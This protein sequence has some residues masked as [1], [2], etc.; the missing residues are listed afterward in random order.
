MEKVERANSTTD[1]RS[2]CE[3]A[4]LEKVSRIFYFL[5]CTPNG[6]TKWRWWPRLL[7]LRLGIRVVKFFFPDP[8]SQLFRSDWS[9][10]GKQHLA[11]SRSRPQYMDRRSHA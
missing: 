1:G 8:I 3:R 7:L 2:R 9:L 6:A 10:E 11:H 5:M 4:S